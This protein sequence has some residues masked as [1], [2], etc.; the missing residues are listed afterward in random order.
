MVLRLSEAPDFVRV[1]LL[2]NRAVPG[3]D[4][5]LEP[6]CWSDA[7]PVAAEARLVRTPEGSERKPDVR[8][9]KDAPRVRSVARRS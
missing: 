7:G 3:S 1:E 6:F 4:D 5:A 9:V 2:R 8:R